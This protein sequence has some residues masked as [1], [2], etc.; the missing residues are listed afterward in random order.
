MVYILL[1]SIALYF[2]T[3]PLKGTVNNEVFLWLL[4]SV[5]TYLIG[6]F[7]KM[8]INLKT[9]ISYG[10]YIYAFPIQQAVF[11]LLG[12]NTNVLLNL[13]LSFCI[14]ALVALLSWKYIEKPFIELKNRAS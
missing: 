5:V 4:I 9:D 10:L 6:T 1:S 11:Y 13:F 8:K 7:S 14:T 12:H 3:I 2:A